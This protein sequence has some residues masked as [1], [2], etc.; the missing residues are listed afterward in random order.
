M[1]DLVPVKE[2]S[3]SQHQDNGRE[4]RLRGTSKSW[5]SVL[6]MVLQEVRLLLSHGRVLATRRTSIL[7]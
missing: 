4:V 6:Q 5:R 7:W 2:N 3:K 1:Q